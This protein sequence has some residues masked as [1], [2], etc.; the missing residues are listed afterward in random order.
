MHSRLV[1]WRQLSFL[2]CTPIP[3]QWLYMHRQTLWQDTQLAGIL[4]LD[5]VCL[6]ST[7]F[8]LHRAAKH[9]GFSADESTSQCVGC[10]ADPASRYRTSFTTSGYTYVSTFASKP[11]QHVGSMAHASTTEYGNDTATQVS[12]RSP[13]KQDSPCQWSH[14]GVSGSGNWFCMSR[15]C[16]QHT[17]NGTTA[18]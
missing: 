13:G 6:Q 9:I 2:L 5:L 11:K 7:W 10:T 12:Y 18:T 3:H 15:E 1:L 4:L 14:M 8:H 17:S 16:A